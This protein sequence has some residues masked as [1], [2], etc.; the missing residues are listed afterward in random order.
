M[1]LVELLAPGQRAPGNQ[2]VHVGVAGVVGNGFGLDAAPGWRADDL[3]RLRL[4]VAEAD[5]LVFAVD[6]QVR[7]LAAG[8]FGERRPGLDRHMA[9]GLGCEHHHHLAGVDVGLDLRHAACSTLGGDEAVELTELPD[10]GLGVPANPFAAVAQLVHQRAQSREALVD[11]RVVT[12]DHGDL[13]SGLA[14]DQLALP[15][16]PVLHVER[17][18]QFAGRVVHQRCQHHLMLDTKLADADVAKFPGEALV[19]IPIAA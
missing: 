11:V 3:A 5:F 9:V 14:R 18:T 10:F 2:L 4:D 12:L 15:L 8:F 13:R 16:R 6:R 1:V 19:D 7:M 17:L